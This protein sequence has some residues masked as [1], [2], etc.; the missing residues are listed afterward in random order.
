[1]QKKVLILS[2]YFLPDINAASY[3]L[4]DLYTSLEK[5]GANITVVTAYPQ[6][7]SVDSIVEKNNIH[8]LSIK[9]VTKKSFLT[10]LRNYFGFMFKSI[11]YC[12]FKL[13]RK[14]MIIFL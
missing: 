4:D 2:Q 3:R 11:Y 5:L 10:Y 7:S 13:K 8:R 14:N 9:K 12:L 6:K 1:M